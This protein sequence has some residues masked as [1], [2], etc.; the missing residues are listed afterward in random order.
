MRIGAGCISGG[1]EK[2]NLII[3]L[4]QDLLCA[5]ARIGQQFNY[6][7]AGS[8]LSAGRGSRQYI[9]AGSGSNNTQ[10]GA[11]HQQGTGVGYYPQRSACEDPAGRLGMVLDQLVERQMHIIHATGQTPG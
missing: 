1:T 7:C 6:R 2:K 11:R 5:L 10:S 8:R 9:Q 4:S 3:F